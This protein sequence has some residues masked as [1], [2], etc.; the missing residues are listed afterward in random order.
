METKGPAHESVQRI[1]ESGHGSQSGWGLETDESR[2][3][4][5][6]RILSIGSWEEGNDFYQPV[7]LMRITVLLTLLAG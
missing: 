4:V 5:G 1:G 7:S 6:L 3:S 2:D